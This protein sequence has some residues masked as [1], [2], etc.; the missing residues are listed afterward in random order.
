MRF[1]SSN[2]QA[3]MRPY[4]EAV[5]SREGFNHLAPSHQFDL[6]VEAISVAV[7]IVAPTVPFASWWVVPSANRSQ[8]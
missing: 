3:W 8:T 2:P 7:V 6:L 4:Y 1:I 5:A